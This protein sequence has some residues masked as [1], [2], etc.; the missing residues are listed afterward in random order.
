MRLITTEE[1]DCPLPQ[2]GE[3]TQEKPAEIREKGDG[4]T[5]SKTTKG[6]GLHCMAGFSRDAY[7]LCL[8]TS[9]M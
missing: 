9:L 2:A 7:C 5:V 8:I 6:E 4:K 3:K 1:D